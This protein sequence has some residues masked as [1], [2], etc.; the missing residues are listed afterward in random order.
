MC[1]YHGWQFNG[2]GSCTKIPQIGDAKA[3]A[4]AVNSERSCVKSYPVHELQGLIWVW[5]DASPSAA[6]ESAATTAAIMPEVDGGVDQDWHRK[7][8]WFMR[9]VPISMETVV[10][11]VMDPCHANFTHHKVQGARSN[12]TG[13]I[14]TPLV[15]PSP[16]GFACEHSSNGGKFKARF[17]YQAP[18]L[19]K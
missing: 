18:C 2:S 10:E 12:E 6:M 16:T 1:S 7:T 15:A 17:G 3:Q 4:T 14:I 8:H 5:A 19:L 11:N 9:D 13:T